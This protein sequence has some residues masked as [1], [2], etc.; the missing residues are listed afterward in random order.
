MIKAVGKTAEDQGFK[1]LKFYHQKNKEIIFPDV[2]L[3]GVYHQQQIE[4]IE[5]N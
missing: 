2:D 5:E 3:T 1:L 4:Q